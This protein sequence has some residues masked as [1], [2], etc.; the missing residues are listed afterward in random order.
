LII[1]FLIFS[2]FS[3]WSHPEMVRFGYSNC[4]TCHVSPSGGGVLNQY[5]REL[6]KEI[7]S[8]WGA[9]GEQYFS[10]GIV[11]LPQNVNLQAFVRALQYRRDTPY[12][13]E[14]RTILMQ[15][16]L[17]G[18]YQSNKVTTVLSLGRQEKQRGGDKIVQPISRRHYVNYQAFDSL[19]LRAGKFSRSFGLNTPYH[20]TYVQRDLGFG[21]ETETYNLEASLYLDHLTLV[22][23]NIFGTFKDKTSY[24]TESGQS[25]SAQY[26]FLNNQKVGLSTFYGK[27]EVQRRSIIGPWLILNYKKDLFLMSETF[28]QK[29]ELFNSGV[30]SSGYVSTN[31]INYQIYRGLIPFFTFEASQLDW[32]VDTSKKQSYGLGLQFFPR[33]HFELIASA[34][35][36]RYYI[37]EG[38]FSDLYLFTFNFYL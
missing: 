32:S 38:Y 35:R 27:D 15:A 12:V 8:T 33:P 16:D 18:S 1:F 21:Q 5:G 23:T 30:N 22:G 25:L 10:Y 37:Q 31:R 13:E 14:A 6:S 19:I 20:T 34:Q 36:D 26:S 2:F 9:K 24:A 29:K 3:A 17:E 7:L 4:I 11:K 28:F